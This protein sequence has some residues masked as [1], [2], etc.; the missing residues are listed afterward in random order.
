MTQFGVQFGFKYQLL[1][2]SSGSI[3][4]NGKELPEGFKEEIMPNIFLRRWS[5][6][7]FSQYFFNTL[8]GHSLSLEHTT[9]PLKLPLILMDMTNGAQ[10]D[11]L[12]LISLL[13]FSITMIV[14]FY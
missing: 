8:K 12:I 4:L 6:Y 5:K 9:F 2:N 1:I 13:G 10:K 3:T 7:N 14:S 11:V